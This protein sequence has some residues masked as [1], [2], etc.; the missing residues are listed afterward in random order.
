MSDQAPVSGAQ[1][2]TASSGTAFRGDAML[3]W[4]HV[5]PFGILTTDAALRV[6]GWNRWLA[7]HSGLPE[8]LVLGRPLVELFPDIADRGLDAPFRRAL[9]GEIA[10]LSTAL[11]RYLLPL[12][13]VSREFGVAHMRQT[14]RVAPLHAGEEIVG[15]I[16]IIEDVT[17]RESH[18]AVLRRQQEHDR[19][20]SSS[21]ALL[22]ESPRPLDAV[23]DLFP[24][25]AVP[26]KLDVFFNFLVAPGEQEMHLQAASGVSAEVRRAFATLPFDTKTPCGLCALRREPLAIP[27]VQSSGEPHAEVARKLGLR[28]YI[29]FPLLI[30]D[31]LL[32]TLSFGSYA[33]DVIAADEIA[34]L[35]TLSQYIAITIDRAQREQALREAQ[36]SLSR[37]AEVLESKVAERTAWLSESVEQLESFSHTV[38]HDL[39]AP[40]RWISGYSE[41]LLDDYRDAIPPAARAIVERLRHAGG[42]LDALTRDLLCFSKIA[43]QE[44]RLEP[45]D[46]AE[47][48]AD[49][50]ALTPGLQD[51]V[52]VVQ[53]SPGAVLAQRTL[54]QQCLANLFDNALKFVR[55]GLRPRIVVRGETRCGPAPGAASAPGTS[56]NATPPPLPPVG[57]ASSR[58]VR[59]WIEDNGIGIAPETQRKI[60]GIFE[61]AGGV[62][63]I[64]G[65]GIGLAIVTRATQ[66]MGGTCGVESQPGAGSRFWL[67]LL[68]PS[69]A[70]PA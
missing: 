17:Q 25:I 5:A 16:T 8:A 58:W 26:L 70:T 59:L 67:D 24:H 30:G 52:V 10:V 20:L 68:A 47:V 63:H 49:L 51:G 3:A 46:V 69:G 55:P 15:T 40:I 57:A 23:A 54:L 66:R 6:R 2:G 34:I 29:A 64:E 42:R 60:F 19:L 27:H 33:R 48:V 28:A 18:A 62:D 22:L 38:A 45:V 36:S 61:R 21:L 41:M 56:V 9:H 4:M 11:H 12:P 65:T 43:R 53:G 35:R 39:R 1:T 50:V 37:H 32:G 14:V 13:P 44:V 7:A 31:R